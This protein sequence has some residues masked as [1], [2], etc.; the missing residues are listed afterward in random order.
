RT[1]RRQVAYRHPERRLR[2][3]RR[4]PLVSNALLH[5]N[6]K[7]AAAVLG[8]SVIERAEDPRLNSILEDAQL[9]A[10]LHEQCAILPYREVGDVFEEHGTRVERGY[11]TQKAAPHPRAR[12]VAVSATLA[13]EAANLGVAR[14][15]KRLT[16]QAGSDQINVGNAPA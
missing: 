8:H 14:T 10:K 5:A 13:H 9:L 6:N 1:H 12:V 3:T 2:P 15:R 16:R 7:E 4:R 11:D